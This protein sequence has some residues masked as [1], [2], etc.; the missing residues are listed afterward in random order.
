MQPPN[1][2]VKPTAHSESQP[3]KYA[4]ALPVSEQSVA[5]ANQPDT[6]NSE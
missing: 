1:L 4:A 6:T 3:V 5:H 2:S